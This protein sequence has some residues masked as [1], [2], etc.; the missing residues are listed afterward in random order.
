M[1]PE[2]ILLS[3]LMRDRP[4]EGR[5]W[6]RA[7]SRS[8]AKLDKGQC[9]TALG[10]LLPFATSLPVSAWQAGQAGEST[11]A[12]REAISEAILVCSLCRMTWARLRNVNTFSS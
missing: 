1:F 10:E 9:L 5:D 4:R 3:W 2:P 7:H 12:C 11:G 8:Q 6:P